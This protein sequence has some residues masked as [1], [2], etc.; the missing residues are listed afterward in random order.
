MAC[1]QRMP[2]TSSRVPWPDVG[3]ERTM[4]RRLAGSGGLTATCSPGKAAAAPP[5]AV[6]LISGLMVA[7]LSPTPR[8]LRLAANVENLAVRDDELIGGLIA[9]PVRW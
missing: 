8:A 3:L 2:L 7:A 5:I 1:S 9:L 6:M 4:A